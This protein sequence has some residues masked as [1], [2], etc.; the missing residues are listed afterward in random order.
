M[1]VKTY[2]LSLNRYN[3]LRILSTKKYHIIGAAIKLHEIILV[4][5]LKFGYI[6]RKKDNQYENLPR[7][8]DKRPTICTVLLP[9]HGIPCENHIKPFH[10]SLD[11]S[12]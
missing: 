12:Y 2:N 3:W 9:Y 5:V 7:I 8:N 1:Y 6:K 11:I 4:I 10:S